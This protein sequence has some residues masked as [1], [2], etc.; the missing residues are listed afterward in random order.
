MGVS[1]IDPSALRIPDMQ[2]IANIIVGIGVGLFSIW[3]L[4]LRRRHNKLLIDDPS[5][6]DIA[7]IISLLKK[8]HTTLEKTG[9]FLQQNYNTLNQIM[10]NNTIFLELLRDIRLQLNQMQQRQTFLDMI[11]AELRGKNKKDI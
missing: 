1:M 7:D 9:E 3:G 6:E 5:S 10:G 11:E 2:N 8:H 4:F